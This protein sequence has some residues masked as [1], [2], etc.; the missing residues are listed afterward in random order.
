M[1]LCLVVVS[2]QP[3]RVEEALAVRFKM[4]WQGVATPGLGKIWDGCDL[5]LLVRWGQISESLDDVT[6]EVLLVLL[7]EGKSDFSLLCRCRG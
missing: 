7:E 1:L 6:T 4:G 5:S 3:S 2:E